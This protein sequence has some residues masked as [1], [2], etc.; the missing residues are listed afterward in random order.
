MVP[1]TGIDSRNAEK[2]K[3]DK[4]VITSI[5]SVWNERISSR[6]LISPFLWFKTERK[7]YD[8]KKEE[9]Y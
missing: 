8:L 2:K 3:F 7:N 5:K 1:K 4:K 9:K 6:Q